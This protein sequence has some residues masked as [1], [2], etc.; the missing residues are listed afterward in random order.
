[1]GRGLWGLGMCSN[2]HYLKCIMY[3]L[4]TTMKSCGVGGDLMVGMP[5]LV[6]GGHL[7]LTK[8]YR[9]HPDLKSPQVPPT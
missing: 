8:V 7:N 9:G 1:M 3:L 6:G 4:G 2:M 5:D